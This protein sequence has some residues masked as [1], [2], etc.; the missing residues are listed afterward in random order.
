[1]IHA[2]SRIF[3]VITK[4]INCKN[5]QLKAKL[6]YIHQY[7]KTPQ[8]GGA[9][10]SY[11]LAKGL[12]EKGFE[13]MMITSHNETYYSERLVDGITVHYLP[14][15]YRNEMGVFKRIYSFLKFVRQAKRLASRLE[16]ID[17]AYITSTPLTV[18]SIGLY[19]KKKKGIPF[20]FEVR[21]LWPK[22]R[23]EMGSSR[24]NSSNATSFD[25]KSKST[26]Q[27]IRSSPSLRACAS[28]SKK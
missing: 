26:K 14:V 4:R 19:L 9:I 24:T 25:M 7:F 13:V 8:E 17:K 18:G 3:V 2:R 12:A 15:P 20:I 23:I 5:Q 27:P 22:A 28:G 6:L 1:V 16:G 21:D 10:R 11:Y